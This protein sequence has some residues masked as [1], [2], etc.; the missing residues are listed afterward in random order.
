MTWVR[1]EGNHNVKAD[2]GSFT[3]GPPTSTWTSYTRDFASEGDYPYYCEL[4]GGPN[5]VGMAGVIQV[6]KQA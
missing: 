3:S 6:R 2:D 5:G 1:S 4:H